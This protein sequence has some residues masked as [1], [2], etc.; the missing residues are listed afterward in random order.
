[1]GVGGVIHDHEGKWMKGGFSINWVS[2]LIMLQ[3][4]GLLDMV[5][6]WLRSWVLDS[7]IGMSMVVVHF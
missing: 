5:F 7:T 6:T 4:F 2:L 1:M 3:N